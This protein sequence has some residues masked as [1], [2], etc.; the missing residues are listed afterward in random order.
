MDKTLEEHNDRLIDPE[1]DVETGEVILTSKKEKFRL[2]ID[3]IN[4]ELT[5]LRQ[6][7]SVLNEELNRIQQNNER[8]KLLGSSHSNRPKSKLTTGLIDSEEVKKD[9][10]FI[11]NERVLGKYSAVIYTSD[12][13]RCSENSIFLH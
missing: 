9:D 6:H 1:Y 13:G 4:T 5:L 12:N 3:E 11:A 10:P 8:P 7:A 2:S